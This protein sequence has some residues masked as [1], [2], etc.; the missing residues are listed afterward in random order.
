MAIFV[1]IDQALN[2]IG[3]CVLLGGASVNLHLIRTPRNLR[4]TE[5]LTFLRDQLQAQLGPYQGQITHAALEAQSLGSLGD[6]DQL[7]QINGIV[8]VV[9]ADLGVAH[10]LLVPPA[11]LKKFVTGHG[12]A[13]KSRMMQASIKY[14]GITIDQDDLCDAHG[15]ARVAE[16]V[17]EQ[18]STIRHQIEATHSLTQPRK[19]RLRRK[20]THDISL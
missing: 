20:S 15:L 9:L 16:E 3:V 7:G 12:N 5:R 19:K 2:K 11:T 6:I 14:W 13:S 4:G 1:G 8:Q 17:Q 10:P 18:R